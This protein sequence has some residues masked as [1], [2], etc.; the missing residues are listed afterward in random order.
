MIQFFEEILPMLKEREKKDV[1]SK[2]IKKLIREVNQ[3]TDGLERQ[4]A[5]CF[6]GLL[7]GNDEGADDDSM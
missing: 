1:K 6:M 7:Y 5:D 4:E 2:E 3:E